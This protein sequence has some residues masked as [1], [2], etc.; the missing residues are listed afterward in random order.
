MN[1]GYA[2]RQELPENLKALFRGVMMMVPD[3]MLI[4]T[5]KLAACGYYENKV[6][7]VKFDLLYKL[8]QLQLTKQTHYDYGLRNILSVLRTAGSA[9]RAMVTAPEQMLM[10]RT[11]RDMNM[12]KFVQEDVPLFLSLI[13]DL[14]PGLTA[15]KATFPTIEKCAEKAAIDPSKNLQW[16]KAREWGGK[17]IQIL[18]SYYVRHGIGL[19]GPTGS[20]KTCALEV[21]ADA[22]SETDVK[23]IITRMNP[24]AITAAQMFGNLDPTTGDWTDGIFAFLWRKAAKAKNCKTFI[25]LDGP[26]DAIWIEN[27]NTVL[28]D[29]K[30][31]TLAN[32]DRIPM[33]PEMKAIFEPENLMNASPATVSRMA[34]IFFSLSIL[35]WEPLTISWLQLRREKEAPFLKELIDKYMDQMLTC[36]TLECRPVMYSTDGIYVTG[37]F[38]ILEELTTPFIEQ[39]QF[40]TDV[41]MERFFIYSLCWSFGALMELDDR[42]KFSTKLMSI[43]SNGP[44]LEAGETA[45]EYFVNEKGEW[46]HWKTKVEPYVY[47]TD[48]EPKFADLLIPTLDSLRYESMLSML[49]PAKK[50][51]LFTGGAGVSKSTCIL[52]YMR[53]LDEEKFTKKMTPFSF[54]TSPQIYQRTLE[55]TVEKRQGTTFGPPGGR[56]GFFFI[57]DIS[58]P[59]INS[60]GDQITNEIVRQSIGEDGVYNLE[61]PGQWITLVDICYC[62]AMMHPGGGR[63]DVPHRLKRQFCLFNVTMPSLEAVDNIFGS[64]IRGRLSD[65]AGVPQ[66]VQAVAAKLTEATIQLWQKTSNK[67]LPTPAKFHYMFNMRELSRVF[68]GI[69]EAPQ[70]TLKDEIYLVKLWRHECERVFTDKLTNGPDKE[71]ETNT[72]LNVLGDV[73]GQDLVSKTSGMCYFVNFL[74]DPI[75]DA[76]GCVENARPKLYEEVHD[77]EHVRAKANEFQTQHNEENK[78]GKLEL[79]LF[80]YALEHLMRINRV[81]NQDPGSMM[82]VGVG[83]SGKQ[84]LTRLASFICGCFTFQIVITK[85]YSTN[86]LFEDIKLLYKTAGIKGRPVC[87]IFTDAEVKDEGFLEYINQILSTGEV[88]GLFAKDEVDA[89]I[90]DMRP[91]AKKEAGKGFIDT[92]DNLWRYFLQRSRAN[93]HIMLCMSP[94]GVLLPGRCRKFPGLIN[95]TTVDWFLPWPELGLKNVAESFIQNFDMASTPEVKKAVM[96]HMG[97][98]HKL[99]QDATLEYLSKYRRYVYVTPKSYLSFLKSY[100]VVYKK[101]KD[102]VDVL[103]VKIDNGLEK[104][105]QAQ[106]DVAKMKIELAASEIILAEA[107]KKSSELMKEIAIST[108]SAEKVKASAKII[109][110]AA[111]EKAVVIGGEKAEVEKDLEAAKPALLEAESALSAIK[112]SDIKNLMALGKPPEVIKIIFDGVLLLRRRTML[113]CTQVEIKGEQCYEPNYAKSQQMMRESTFLQELQGFPKECITDEDC[114]LLAPYVDHP[115]FTVEMAAKASEM[116]IGLCKWVKAMVTYHMIAKVVIPKMDGLRL[117]EAELAAAQKKLAGAEAELNAAQAELDAMQIKFDAA[118]SEKQKLQDASDNTKRKMNSATELLTGLAGERDRWTKQSADF[119]DQMSRLAGDCAIACGFMSYTGPFNKPFRDLLLDVKFLKDLTE[120]KIPVTTGLSVSSMLTDEATTGQWNLQ[121]LPTD[122]LSIQNGILTTNASRYPLMIDPQGQGLAW[123]K[124]KEAQNECKETSFVDKAF[125]NSLED[126]LMFGRPLL[127]AGVEET[128]DPV[129][130]PILDK[131]FQKKGKNYIVAL[132]DKECDV[133]PM[134]F[135][136]YIT[137]SLGN[138]HYTPELSAKVTI[139][140]F[141]VTMSGLEDQLLDRVVQFEKPELQLERTKLK[142]EV[143]EC[144]A[145]I[146]QLQDDLLFK[147]SNCEGSLLDDPDIIDVLNVTKKTSAEVTEKLKNAGEAELRI[148][149]ACEE[150]RPVARRGSLIYF[151]IAELSPVNTM[152]QTSLAQFIGVFQQSMKEAEK[153]AIPARRI[154]NIVDDLTFR[155]FLYVTRG[156]L[157]IHKK[158]YALLLALKL[159]LQS[160]IITMDHFG[161]LVKGGGALDINSVK[162]KPKEWIKDQDWLNIIQLS[163]SVPLFKE[164]PDLIS[165]NEGAW[166]QWYDQEAPEACPVPDVEDRLDKMHKMLVVR[167]LRTDRT[168]VVAD[169]YI[170]EAIG[171]K[172]IDTYPLSLDKLYDDVEALVDAPER[173]PVIFILTPGSDPTELINGLAKKKKKEVLSVSMGR[174]QDVI[175]RRFLDS[176]VTSGGWALFQN[177][178]LAIGY[179]VELQQ[180]MVLIE[181]VDPEFRVWVTAEALPHHII[182]GFPLALLQISIKVTN[183]APVGMRAGL[184]RTYAW[185]TQDMLDTVPRVEWRQLLWVL[186][187]LHSITQERRKFGAMGW[188]VPYEF[189]QSDL[190]A[191]AL[192][193][194]NHVLD[195]EMKKAKDVTWTTVRYMVAEIQYGGKITDDYDR[196]CMFT[197]AE[198]FFQQSVMEPNYSFLK[199]YTVPL[200]T[201][202]NAFREHVNTYPVTDSPEVVGL[203]MNADLVFRLN[204]VAIVFSTILDTMPKGGGGGGGQTREE[205]V[206]EVCKD[207][208]SKT[209][210]LF[211]Q[212]EL[213]TYLKKAGETKPINICLKQEVDVLDKV[214]GKVIKTL[215]DLQLAIDGTIVMSDDLAASLDALANAK[216]P[217][218]WLKGAWFSPSSGIWFASLLS[219]AKQWSDWISTGRPKS[220]W[221]PGFTNGPG[222][223]TAGRQEVTRAHAGWAL[224]AVAVW[225]EVTKFEPEDVKEPPAEGVYV[226]GMFLDGC[227]WS[228]KDSKLV[229]APAKVLYVPLPCMWVNAV[230]KATKKLDYLVYDCPVYERKDARKRGM[231]A[232]Q[233]NFVFC[234]EIRTE[235]QPAKWVLRGVCLITYF[236]E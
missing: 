172:Y 89:I 33:T 197:F 225:T 135:K 56:K 68:A 95:C 133:E 127:L 41:H 143:N 77:V 139:I 189:N 166:R 83:G 193:L 144:K 64:I 129:L 196:R 130:D 30:L 122:D 149:V 65:R 131:A 226:H 76:D 234:P 50:P 216:A 1:P 177:C 140:D 159:Q 195:M 40:L 32:G 169:E 162:K 214:L 9:K 21:L 174:D 98:V 165:R 194:Q 115:L 223:L 118:M 8:C 152:Y 13:G 155:T 66:T 229:E 86:N 125:R 112:A 157:E 87:F 57:D 217:P 185:V 37:C 203:N 116:A 119:A 58:M 75:I 84:S 105:Y 62:C 72:I 188:S 167:S 138:P 228:K 106:D 164:L 79:V 52:M 15:E 154:G 11:L 186:S 81:L 221:L 215:K 94:V 38:R 199:G 175:A 180:Q 161:S 22:L 49:V 171:T 42:V 63:N 3:F 71:W 67:M 207:L 142:T 158:I 134:N 55:S 44:K 18:E 25:L 151:L 224:D 146:L 233:P 88:S 90:G 110:D 19:V 231:T 10:M 218:L 114:E 222:F 160:E 92:A 220:Y 20:G 236:G 126:C 230:Q 4:M 128:L 31:L 198:K 17:V 2:G 85:T 201:D 69:F 204:N 43:A 200:V 102:G 39:K 82:L 48:Y 176:S 210:K 104:L 187:H 148:K 6:I 212:Q 182:P 23:H 209:P 96:V 179:M 111:N 60:W 73:F 93:L 178:H 232:A 170:E 235:E 14:F 26:V 113:K 47:P 97:M 28:D 78:I 103:K 132:A 5:V 168:M 54:V 190:N 27:L 51:V 181:R 208:L 61:K 117:K 124:N 227:G 59:V 100:L 184:K 205:M 219:R 101:E 150:Y 121:G 34:I 109:A 36:V 141:T 74:G 16:S 108:A 137:C 153:A 123:I 12:S 29:N 206:V 91:V 145:Q 99:V 213:K 173:T 202:I 120:R 107:V 163:I 156:Y 46:A 147:L 53:N 191:C 45:Y 136:L 7:A 211:D 35:G 70:N 80:E 183:E 192:F 24:K